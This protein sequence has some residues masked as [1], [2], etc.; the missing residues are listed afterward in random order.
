MLQI[1][2]LCVSMDNNELL[3]NINLDIKDGA[4]H[5]LNGHNGSGKTTL[6]STI[7][8]NPQ[9]KITSGQITFDGTDITSEN[10][11]N[12]ALRGIFIGSQNVPEI[13]GLT[14]L[15]LLKHSL[16]AHT[17][18]QT[19]KDLSMA[20]FL[21]N[22]ED[23]RE[24]LSIPRDWLNR[25]I[26]VGFS[27]GERKRIMLLRLIMTKPKFAILDEADS[28]SDTTTQKLIADTIKGMPETTFMFISH[29]PAFIDLIS[30]TDTTTLSDGRII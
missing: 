24:Q 18:F 27:G 26:N 25:S 6:V 7:A 22:I 10:A 28:G 20:Q 11:T 17:H 13:P 5:L 30:P 15:S 4:R 23:A 2:N 19:G 14:V 9:Y 29:Q 8:G 21:S 3:H 16:S 1:K 12:R